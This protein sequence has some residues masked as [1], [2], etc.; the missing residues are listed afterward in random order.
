MK[1]FLQVAL[2]VHSC[3]GCVPLTKARLTTNSTI[4]DVRAEAKRLESQGWEIS[5]SLPNPTGAV[6]WSV[7]PLEAAE[8]KRQD[9][10]DR[11]NF[12]WRISAERWRDSA[13]FKAQ[14]K[15]AG[16]DE[17]I[18]ISHPTRETTMS[19]GATVALKVLLPP[20]RVPGV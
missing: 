12:T 15:A 1:R 5:L 2:L 6:Q 17:V 11:S 19:D 10:N 9:A 4:T 7:T 8:V 13:P 14:V 18:S 3:L 16:I 20:T